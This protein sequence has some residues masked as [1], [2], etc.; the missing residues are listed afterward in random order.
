MLAPSSD[1]LRAGVGLKFNQIKR[2]TRSYVRDRTSQATGTLTSYA[3][4]GGLFAVAAI[5]LIAACLVGITALFRWIE[6]K[7]GLFPA[8]G[9]IGALLVVISAVCAGVAI[10]KLRKPPPQFPSL[11]SRLRVAVTASPLR[12]G[13]LAEKHESAATAAEAMR[14]RLERMPA[15]RGVFDRNVQAGLAAAAL[16]LAWVAARRRQQARR[17]TA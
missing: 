9:A 4:A 16:L 2:A 3:V 1:L 8:F 14:P 17:P 6:I 11:A 13:E 10:V 12:S 15:T 7:Y 5:F